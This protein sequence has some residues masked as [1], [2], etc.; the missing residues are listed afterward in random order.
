MLLAGLGD[1]RSCQL[2]AALVDMTENDYHSGG[3]LG[4]DG[5]GQLCVAIWIWWV[6][7]LLV[8][9]INRLTGPT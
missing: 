1:V 7:A 4:E 6:I 2:T 9:F 5:G 8:L 3:L